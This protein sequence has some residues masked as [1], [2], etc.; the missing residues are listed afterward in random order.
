[1]SVMP[2]MPVSVVMVSYY[3][4]QVL[5]DSVAALLAGRQQL[6]QN[7]AGAALQLIIVDN[8]NDEK[9]R[10]YLHQLA[11]DKQI[12]LLS[13]QGNIGFAAGSNL[14]VSRA[15][16]AC[17]LL[18][19]PDCILPPDALLSLLAR[20]AAMDATTLLSPWIVNR[21]GSE[22]RGLRRN[23]L[24]PMALAIEMLKLD[25]LLP[26]LRHKRFNLVGQ[27]VSA[28]LLSIPVCSGACMLMP[29]ALFHRLGGFDERYFLH[30]E[31]IDF[32]RRLVENGG[33]ILLDTR[34]SITHVKGTSNASK[35]QVERHKRD[36]FRYYFSRYHPL[37]WVS[38]LGWGLQLMIELK[39]RLTPSD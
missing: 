22:Q 9:T 37:F 32:C 2:V 11:A 19:N 24:T 20:Q 7:A 5:Q 30:V 1:M 18:I 12:D 28:E 8:G 27:P 16:H 10:A 26:S 6:L 3:T 14:G 38:P 15:K 23:V 21:N 29:T 39:Y 36:G 33:R 17:L 13:G 35:R 34:V 4:G 25:K 31:D